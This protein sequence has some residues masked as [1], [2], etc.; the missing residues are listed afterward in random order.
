M[1]PCYSE[2]PVIE[3][4]SSSPGFLPIKKYSSHSERTPYYTKQSLG[5][6]GYFNGYITL[7]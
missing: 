5:I 7:N 6:I 1:I 4:I 2:S 3:N